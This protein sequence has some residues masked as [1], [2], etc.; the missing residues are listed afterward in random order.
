MTPAEPARD[1]IVSADVSAEEWDAYVWAH[2]R[3]R[4]YHLW[5][6][7]HVFES[8]F[9]HHT[10]YLVAR[11][12]GRGISG[13]LPLVMTDHL[14]FGHVMVSLPFVNG[15]GVL[16]DSDEV[17]RALVQ[18]AVERARWH[19][20]SQVELRNHARPSVA[21]PARGDGVTMRLT[22]AERS[23]DAW[24]R[25][26]RE[27]RKHLQLA[28]HSDATCETG[29]RDLVPEFYAVLAEH[30]RDRGTPVHPR[31][32]FTEMLD[33]FP[34]Q[35][36]LF[37]MRHG[38]KAVACAMTLTFRSTCEI[39]SS[40]SLRAYRSV[41]PDTWLHWHL[42][43]QAMND[44]ALAIDFGLSAP[45]EGAGCFATRLGA[46]AW[47]TSWECVPLSCRTPPARRSM[48][49]RLDVARL[50]WQR[51]P[52]RLANVIGPRVVRYLA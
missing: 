36:R 28:E 24:R 14:M 41:A 48:R 23:S 2:P 25:L 16:A 34:G 45:G 22:L 35:C 47:R 49:R 30:A 33:R 51:L 46:T 5:A 52:L 44:G 42:I 31:R 18:E 11:R 43:R 40:G 26:D 38:Q 50:V 17:A 13:V 7:R 19:G 12:A 15:G 37:V 4:A 8:A 39:L 9:R 20:C 27:V 32:W 3:A 10:E 1:V 6:W 21:A 29:G